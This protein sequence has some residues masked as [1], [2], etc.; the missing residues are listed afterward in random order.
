MLGQPISML[1]PQVVGFKLTGALPEG[2]TATDLVLTV[3]E[4]LRRTGVV[5][6]FVEF[7]G[8]RPRR[9]PA[10]RPRDDRE[11]GARVRRDVR[12]LP[13]RRA[14]RSTTC[15]SPAG[16]TSASRS[17]RRTARSRASSTTPTTRADVLAGRRARPRRRRAEPRRP[18][19]P[20]GPRAARDARSRRSSRRSPTFGVDYAAGRTTKAVADAFPASDPPADRRRVTR[21]PVGASPAPPTQ[22]SP[23]RRTSRSSSDGETFELDARR[24]RDRRDHE[25]HE[26]VEPVRDGRRRACSRRTPSSAGSTRKPWVKSSLAPGSKVVT[27]YLDARR[28]DAVPRRARLQPR[29]LRL[30]DLH[31]QLGPAARSRSR[32]AIADG[33]LVVVRR[34]LG[35]P[36]LRGAHPSRGEGELPRLAAARRRLRARRPHGHRPRD[37]AARAATGDGNDVYLRDIWPSAEEI[38]GDDRRDGP[39]ARCSRRRYAD[40]F[41]GDERW[42]ALPVPE[43]DLFAWDADSTYVRQPPYFDGHAA[44]S[45][46]RSTDVAR[47][48]RASSWSATAS[49][50]TTSRPPARSSRTAR[51]GTT[52]SSTASSARTSTRTA[53][54]AA[55]TR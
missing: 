51:P 14:R 23:L 52:S 48:A 11:H 43:G 9:A 17:S 24:G 29:R 50:P 13:G 4:I 39:S 6:K 19:P 32:S 44:A 21:R 1:V 37:R 10:R 31:R 5:G 40:V 33:D 15:A 49:R 34:A 2:A 28:P 46:A 47:R 27:D 55:T 45:P 30:H 36:Q 41:A 53:R 26:H 38:A 54:G 20:A 12:L 8:A 35:Q 22:T 16:P 25:L 7:F 18:A 42:R 3:T